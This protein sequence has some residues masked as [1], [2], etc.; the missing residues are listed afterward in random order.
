MQGS[1]VASGACSV[2]CCHI[3]DSSAKCLVP[4]IRHSRLSIS[5][6]VD[7]IFFTVSVASGG[8]FIRSVDESQTISSQ[9]IHRVVVSHEKE[10]GMKV[11]CPD[12]FVGF[13]VSVCVNSSLISLSPYADPEKIRLQHGST[14]KP[15]RFIRGVLIGQIVGVFDRCLHSCVVSSLMVLFKHIIDLQYS[16]RLLISA[17]NVVGRRHPYL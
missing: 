16:D 8:K 14:A 10:F 1:P 11:E 2:V 12:V 5:R 6:W 3:E 15:A 9:L 4:N 13:S 7:D 17:T